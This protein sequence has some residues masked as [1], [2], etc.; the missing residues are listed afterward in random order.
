MKAFVYVVETDQDGNLRAR[1]RPVKVGQMIGERFSVLSGLEA[2]VAV[3]ADGSFKLRDGVLI[4][5]VSLPSNS[6]APAPAFDSAPASS[7]MPPQE[8]AGK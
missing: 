4:T 5:P 1:E 6:P 8:T 7:A 3:V 2:G